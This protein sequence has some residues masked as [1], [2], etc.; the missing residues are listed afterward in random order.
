MCFTTGEAPIC[1]LSQTGKGCTIRS[2][3]A[4]TAANFCPGSNANVGSMAGNSSSGVS[5]GSGSSNSSAVGCNRLQDF[6]RLVTHADEEYA[7][8]ELEG[9]IRSNSLVFNTF[10]FLQ[11]LGPLLVSI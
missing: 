11:V 9:H 7:K 3:Q 8:E 2:K 1:L 4:V 6:Q 10:I 5:Q